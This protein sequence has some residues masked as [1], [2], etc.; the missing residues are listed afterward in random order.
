MKRFLASLILGVVVGAF[1][2]QRAEAVLLDF[3]NSN[4]GTPVL[5]WDGSPDGWS[6]GGGTV[7]LIGHGAGGTS[8][9]FLP[10]N[11][12]YIDLDGST[13]NAAD[14]FSYTFTGLT[15]GT[16]MLSFDLAGNQRNG[17]FEEVTV[18]LGSFLGVY[19]SNQFTMGTPFTTIS[20]LATVGD[21]PTLTF[22]SI[23]GD[24]IG[25]LLDNVDVQAVPEPTTLLLL[26][27]GLTGLA[28]RRR[29]R[30]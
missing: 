20:V 18:T 25:L 27:G 11:G 2:A 9:D 24:N 17:A 3:N 15:A 1:S 21:N 28:L 8:F 5:N 6:V 16:Y 7:D 4:S 19:N 30:G 10:G 22:G 13:G 26:G 14:A 12:M 23:G 29:R